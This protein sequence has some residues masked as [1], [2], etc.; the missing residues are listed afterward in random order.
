M[1][2]GDFL[3]NASNF[4]FEITFWNVAF[5]ILKRLS[6]KLSPFPRKDWSTLS[7]LSKKNLFPIQVQNWFKGSFESQHFGRP[8]RRRGTSKSQTI[9]RIEPPDMASRHSLKCLTESKKIKIKCLF[10][11]Q[12][13]LFHLKWDFFLNSMPNL[14]ELLRHVFYFFVHF[15]AFTN[16]ANV[17]LVFWRLMIRNE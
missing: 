7:F 15:K 3:Q 13:Q 5:Y 2:L 17:S 4:F 8:E 1:F 11:W 6:V 10:T 16:E 12:L 9:F 14:F